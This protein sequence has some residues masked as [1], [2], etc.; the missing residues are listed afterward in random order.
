M[1]VP[2]SYFP[3]PF[4]NEK[5][6]ISKVEAPWYETSHSN[7]FSEDIMGM[8]V[9]EDRQLLF[10]TFY[11]EWEKEGKPAGKKWL[12]RFL[13][14]YH[15]MDGVHVTGT[16]EAVEYIQFHAAAPWNAGDRLQFIYEHPE[17]FSR[18]ITLQQMIKEAKPKLRI[19]YKL[20][21]SHNS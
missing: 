13:Q 17:H 19:H 2:F 15:W 7:Y 5:D 20:K 10:D 1:K 18:K 11:K 4:Y 14:L 9:T 8:A 12:S 21:L 6:T 16:A 3:G